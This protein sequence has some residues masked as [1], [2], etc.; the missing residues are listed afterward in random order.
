MTKPGIGHLLFLGVG[1]E[2][3]N[4]GSRE[5]CAPTEIR[6][7]KV[8]TYFHGTKAPMSTYK[9]NETISKNN[10]LTKPG[11][12]RQLFLAVGIDPANG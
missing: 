5:F 10:C 12:E 6:F 1:F 8:D 4:V 2:P 7:V 11:V 3:A 9:R